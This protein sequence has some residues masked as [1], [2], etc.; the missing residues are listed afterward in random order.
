MLLR[1]N[2]EVQLMALRPIAFLL[3]CVA[4][5]G[6]NFQPPDRGEP[7]KI[8]EDKSGNAYTF[9]DVQQVEGTR[10][11]T[12]PIILSNRDHAS[13][14]FSGSY[15]GNDERN[16]L[17]VDSASGRARKVLPDEK[18]EIVNWIEP[19]RKS[20]SRNF[21]P[22]EPV[23]GDDASTVTRLYA[24]VV[25]RP[26]K[27]DK[28]PATYD[29]LAGRFED[30]QQIWIAN[31]LSGIESIWITPDKKLAMIAAVGD[32]GIYRLYDPSTLRQL[33]QTELKL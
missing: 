21:D 24:A 16:R 26:G 5:A 12:M 7:Q 30:G 15:T 11:F 4:L 25:K 6:C 13:G 2:A 10:F 33:L 20:S 31:G 9:G 1:S 27:G 3:V 23:S 19:D 28:D 18:F 29:V 17:I 32:H 8:A 14:S 22:D